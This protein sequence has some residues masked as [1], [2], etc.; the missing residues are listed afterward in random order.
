MHNS[1]LTT[2]H[3]CR[4]HNS[5]SVHFTATSPLGPFTRKDVTQHRFSHNPSATVL[6]DG[7]WLLYHLGIGRPRYNAKQGVE[8]VFTECK[9]GQ[10]L[11]KPAE[12]NSSCDS[13]NCTGSMDG[14]RFTQVLHSM[15]GPAGPWVTHNITTKTHTG[16]ETFG[17]NDNGAPLAPHLLNHSSA[18]SSEFSIM[19]SARNRYHGCHKVDCSELGIARAASWVGPYVLDPLPV[20]EGNLCKN[21]TI[22]DWRVYCEDPYYWKD[23]QDGTWHALCN[24]KDCPSK[25]PEPPDPKP[26]YPYFC[27][28]HGMHA[29]SETGRSGTWHWQVEEPAYNNS[30]EMTNGSTI[31]IGRRERPHLLFHDG[32]PTHLFTAVTWTS[33]RSWTFGQA[34]K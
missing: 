11:G 4:T 19:F 15:V 7:S 6:P 3:A 10:T 1:T 32:R 9:D 8:P 22:P 20:C 18:P 2:V 25:P 34:L 29:F 31:R 13:Y 30:V 14:D 16:D 28:G 26:S 21:G 5:Q 23:V 12:W 17:I 24:S 27:N 33:D